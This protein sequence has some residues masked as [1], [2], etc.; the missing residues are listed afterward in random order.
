[1]WGKETII[2]LHGVINPTKQSLRQY[3]KDLCETI[4]MTP[5]GNPLIPY[6]GEGE[7]KGFTLVQLIETSAI[8][9]HFAEN[10]NSAYINIFSCKDYDERKA[11]KF[12][13]H[14]FQAKTARVTILKRK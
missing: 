7:A 3:A 8:V 9:G 4:E 12:T 6:F 14:F 13:K 2:D 11:V 1:M 5:Y 10:S